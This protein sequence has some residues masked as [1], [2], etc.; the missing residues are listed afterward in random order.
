MK[1][2]MKYFA[3]FLLL[4]IIGLTSLYTYLHYTEGFTIHFSTYNIQKEYAKFLIEINDDFIDK[5]VLFEKIAVDGKPLENYTEE[6]KMA[7]KDIIISE[8]NILSRLQNTKPIESN[9]DYEELYNDISKSYALYIQGQIMKME[10]IYQ[11]TEG[12]SDE[13]FTIGD[14]VTTLVGNFIIE[15]DQLINNIRNTD[16]YMKYTVMDGLDLNIGNMQKE[17]IEL[18]KDGNIILDENKDYIYTPQK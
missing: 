1:K 12:L 2:I 11:T 13:R 17:K 15:Y 14:S 3:I 7:I 4:L 10:Y 8:N 5:M 6:E 9:L 16:Y 18:D